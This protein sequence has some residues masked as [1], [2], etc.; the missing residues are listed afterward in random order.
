MLMLVVAATWGGMYNVMKIVETK[1]D[2]RNRVLGI[3][4]S[5]VISSKHMRMLRRNDYVP[6]GIGIWLFLSVF[7]LAIF[8]APRVTSPNPGWRLVYSCYA[9]AGF[10]MFAMLVDIWATF[11]EWFV[12][13][14]HI[15]ETERK[16]KVGKGP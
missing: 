11:E 16:E 9:I 2:V 3:K 13:D 12:M 1:N 14:K 10:G 7:S 6:L 4:D 15:K 8:F 5:L